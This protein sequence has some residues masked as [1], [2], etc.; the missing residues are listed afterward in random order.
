MPVATDMTSVCSVPGLMM[1]ETPKQ[2]AEANSNSAN[3]NPVLVQK[4][5]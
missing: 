1:L 2:A 5:S 3:S 4:M